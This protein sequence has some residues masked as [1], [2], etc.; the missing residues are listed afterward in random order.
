M[1]VNISYHRTKKDIESLRDDMEGTNYNWKSTTVEFEDLV[2]FTSSSLVQ[3]S[4]YRFEN[5]VRSKANSIRGMYQNLLIFDIDDGMSLT[6]CMEKLIDYTFLITTTS[7]HRKEKKGKIADRFRVIMPMLNAPT[8][9]NVY[10]ES[11]NIIGKELNVDKQANIIGSAYLG[12]NGAQY[13]FNYGRS[14]DMSKVVELA[15]DKILKA[16]R[17]RELRLSM[18]SVKGSVNS[19][20]IDTIELKESLDIE[21]TIDIFYEL[22]IEVKKGKV[23]VR[24]ERSPSVQIYKDGKLFDFGTH[25]SYDIFDIIQHHTGMSFKESL[26]YVKNYMER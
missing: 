22:G 19:S 25:I 23:S 20:L 12:N 7:N 26:S 18:A 1:K 9:D 10:Q 24:N 2:E 11:L 16:E 21:D 6:E 5:G 8:D 15:T 4:Q 14:Y 13:A 3:Y 17:A